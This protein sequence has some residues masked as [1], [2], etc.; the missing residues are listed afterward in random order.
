MSTE[1]SAVLVGDERGEGLAHLQ[2]D[3]GPEGLAGCPRRPH[4][5]SL[6]HGVDPAGAL[7]PEDAQ[8]V[9]VEGALGLA[10]QLGEGPQLV[11]LERR[12]RGR[13]G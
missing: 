4:A 9:G 3:A 12:A 6:G 2:R 8:L 10:Q 5:I 13:S 7:P 1:A 11:E